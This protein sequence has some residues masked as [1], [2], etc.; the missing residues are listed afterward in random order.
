MYA[1]VKP[2]QPPLADL[3]PIFIEGF[4]RSSWWLSYHGFDRQILSM[5]LAANNNT[6]IRPTGRAFISELR[7][8]AT[9]AEMMSY[10]AISISTASGLPCAATL[11]GVGIKAASFRPIK[12]ELRGKH[13]ADFPCRKASQLEGSKEIAPGKFLN[14][15]R[16]T[17]TREGRANGYSGITAEE[18]I[19]Q[20]RQLEIEDVPRQ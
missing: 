11:P 4:C 17:N 19:F 2:V 20:H 7:L 9:R 13:G 15:H 8:A 5:L 16:V 10:I 6:S 12:Q 3:N 18:R 1:T 14:L